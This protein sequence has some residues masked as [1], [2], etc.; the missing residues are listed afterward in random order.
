MC[1]MIFAAGQLKVNWLI[2]DMIKMASNKNEKHEEN[3]NFE[4]LHSDGWGITYLAGNNLK[5][6][7]SIKPI[8]DDPQIEQ[9]KKLNTNLIVLHA[10]KATYGKLNLANIHPF[11]YQ[12]QNS[13]FV[14]FHNGTVRDKLQINPKYTINGETDSEKFFY[15][16]ING[17]SE[18][19][20]LDELQNKL[21]NLKNFSG[22]N[23]VLTNG[24]HSYI[25]DWY[26]LN[27]AYYSMKMLNQKNAIIISSEVL[28]HY[29]QA[30]WQLLE[31]FSLV[32]IRTHDLAIR[33]K[34]LSL[35]S[36]E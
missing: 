34:V 12:N 32:S 18:E 23:F 27:P 20:N 28:P 11:E 13:N 19:S 5:T 22:A 7:R 31:N 4:F 8:Y 36:I 14:F 9:F 6:F 26:T 3:T 15:Y 21:I 33:K 2:D 24:D 17:N 10:R 1:R 25:A 29:R 35:N 16:L 30:A